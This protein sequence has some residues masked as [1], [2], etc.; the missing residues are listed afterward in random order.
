MIFTPITHRRLCQARR[1]A[2]AFVALAFSACGGPQSD[3]T[4]SSDHEQ[5]RQ[6][7][8][9]SQKTAVDAF[10]FDVTVKE[11]GKTRTFRL[12]VY[13]TDSSALV[14]ARGYIGKGLARGVWRPDTSRFYFPTENRYFVGNIDSLVRCADSTS[15]E[16]QNLLSEILRRD[17]ASS[18]SVD[19]TKEGNFDVRL[20]SDEKM[21]ATLRASA[22][23]FPV[24]LEYTRQSPSRKYFLERFTYSDPRANREVRGKRR[25]LK[26]GGQIA[27]SR[28]AVA[29]PAD[30]TPL[31]R[32]STV[33][34]DK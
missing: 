17:S 32:D 10:L 11:A 9:V 34:K 19:S 18:A 12:D 27:S 20:Q 15:T 8:G 25:S 2:I 24:D 13:L 21:S 31:E 26:I 6:S 23:S 28:F 33:S 3:E 30:A 29:I 16:L 1:S 22:C 14:T 4:L 5:D 7:T